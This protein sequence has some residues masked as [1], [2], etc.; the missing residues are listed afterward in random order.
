[1]KTILQIA[2]MELQKMFYSPIAWIVLI[3]F[4]VQSGFNLMGAF[5]RYVTAAELGS[6]YAPGLTRSIYAGYS[7]SFLN[8][9]QSY[10]YLYIPMITMGLMSKEF[11]SGSIKLLYSSPISNAQIIFGKYA[12]VIT[13]CLSI[14]SILLLQC[15]FGMFTMKD[16]DTPNIVAALLG[17][18]LMLA[19]Y[20]A[21]GLFWS[22]ITSYQIVALIGTFATSYLLEAARGFGQENPIIREITWWLSLGGRTDTFLGGMITTEDFLYFILVGG[23]FLA[24]SIF[25]LKGIKEK[26]SKFTSLARYTG[27]ILIAVTLGYLTALPSNKIYWDLTNT[28][29][30]TLTAKSQEVVKNLK[31]K[32]DMTTY[33]NLYGSYAYLGLP[34]AQKRLEKY[35]ENYTRFYPS[36]NI[37]FKYYYDRNLVGSDLYIFE[38]R[39]KNNSDE[40]ILKKSLP[41]YSLSPEDVKKGTEYLDDIDLNVEENRLVWQITT[42]DGRKAMLRTFNDNI[43]LPEESQIT[44]A[45]KRATQDLPKIGFVTGH[46]ERSTDNKGPRGYTNI[47]KQKP[48]RSSLINN[49]MDFE[50]IS[51]NKPVDESIDILMLIEPRIAIEGSHLKHLND[52]IARGGNLIISADLKR[53]DVLN[54]IVS[55]FGVQYL[56]GQVVEFNKGYSMD[57]VAAELTKESAAIA[58]RIEG[59]YNRKSVVAMTGALGIEYKEQPDFEYI[60]LLQADSIG[61]L[62]LTSQTSVL[63]ELKKQYADTT[64]TDKP[65]NNPNRLNLTGSSKK[66]FE[67]GKYKGSWTELQTTNFVDEIPFFDA[68]TGEV[69]GPILTGLAVTRKVNS[70]QQKIVILGD[71]DWLQNGGVTSFARGLPIANFGYALGLFYWLTDEEAPTDVRSPQPT[72]NNIYLNKAEFSKYQIFYKWVLPIMLLL[73]I[74]FI[75]LRRRGR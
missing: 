71:S 25:K 24:F 1:M 70:K 22:T 65:T 53:Q 26:P 9:M 2:K 34:R 35:F 21:I 32:V 46:G 56:E 39:D 48:N 74:I 68:S 13:F 4:A 20:S 17:I 57:V 31:G 55:Q 38:R 63:E 69:G 50:D 10:I 15:A 47:M 67:Q 11:S 40:D 6:S 16:F 36:L 52:F 42:E 62:P 73:T 8:A 3:I 19:A 30:N 51:L 60:P 37:D 44:A 18:F 12:A 29:R 49:G 23:M 41:I 64:S 75:W 72:D 27:I 59:I 28:K 45:F 54:P 5:D 14:M 66:T 33:V 7:F 58:Y 61:T 43:R